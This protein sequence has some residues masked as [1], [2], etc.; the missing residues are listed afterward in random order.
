MRY[1]AKLDTHTESALK[2]IAYFDALVE[3]RATLEACVRA[4]AGLSQCTAGLRD[5]ASSWMLR[6]NYRG[7]AAD[8]TATP[9]TRHAVRVGER[10]VGE[11]WLER[12]GPAGPLDDLVVERMALAA[13]IL[14]RTSARPSRSTASLLDVLFAG[15][16]TFQER[17]SALKLLGIA[18]ERPMGLAAV[19]AEDPDHLAGGLSV[20]CDLTREW[21]ATDV[22]P[23]VCSAVLGNVGAVLTQPGFDAHPEMNGGK[24]HLHRLPGLRVG[25]VHRATEPEVVNAWQQAQTATRFCGVLGFGNVV[26]YEELGS[27]ATLASLPQPGIDSNEDVRALTKLASTARG[28]AA[29]GTLEQRLACGSL[30][31]AAEA[32]HL[33]HSSVSYRLEQAEK[34]LDL[35]LD[36]P[37]SRLRAQLAVALWRISTR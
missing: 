1:V 3:H 17:S 14:W 29:L 11:V 4:A 23:V 6:F 9:T 31:E 32:L 34:A 37:K 5:D 2:V 25:T 30:R 15:S 33:H 27:L 13:G 22:R 7:I 24:T 28:L 19:V 20:V 10:N 35:E 36:D 21:M 18:T 16:A 8:G 26:G 12:P